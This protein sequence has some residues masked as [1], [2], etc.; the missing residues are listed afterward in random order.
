VVHG[1]LHVMCIYPLVT[2]TIICWVGSFILIWLRPSGQQAIQS[3][4]KTVET[5]VGGALD[6]PRVS[7]TSC[8]RPYAPVSIISSKKI[9]FQNLHCLQTV[10][11][12]YHH[13]H[14][15]HELMKIF[16]C[17]DQGPLREYIGNKVDN[18]MTRN[19][20][21]SLNPFLSKVSQMSFRLTLNTVWRR[22]ECRV[23]C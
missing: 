3:K 22:L 4:N 18:D 21:K 14:R 2:T 9:R 13:L 20:M 7:S 6:C 19:F 23:K 17:E 16:S 10:A 11:N 5:S 15:Q 8:G 1:C 12:R